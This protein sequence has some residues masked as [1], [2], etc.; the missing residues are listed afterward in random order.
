MS[1]VCPALA[2]ATERFPSVDDLIADQVTIE[3][4]KLPTMGAGQGQ[5]ICV[6]HLG[7]SSRRSHRWAECR[8]G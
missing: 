8:E 5:Q 1:F 4:S 6:G 7:K 2:D 3:G